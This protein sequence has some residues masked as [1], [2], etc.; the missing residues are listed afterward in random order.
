M[1]WNRYDGMLPAKPLEGKQGY[2]PVCNTQEWEDLPDL[3]KAMEWSPLLDYQNKGTISAVKSVIFDV[4]YMEPYKIS[5]KVSVHPQEVQK[6]LYCLFENAQCHLY[7]VC[8]VELES[9]TRL[10]AKW[11]QDSVTGSFGIYAGGH[12]CGRQG[13]F[14]GFVPA[15]IERLEDGTFQYK[16]CSCALTGNKV[17]Y[18]YSN[19]FPAPVRGK[20]VVSLDAQIAGAQNAA[21]KPEQ[22][23]S[24]PMRT[25]QR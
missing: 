21:E 24:A 12:L 23:S 5:A 10:G 16:S 19:P 4:T 15:N 7:S 1:S 17:F 13:G 9:G 25:E 8:G 3:Y 20:G 6:L 2:Y 14:Q 18:E 11:L 22:A